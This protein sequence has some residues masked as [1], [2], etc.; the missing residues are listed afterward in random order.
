MGL[1]TQ[2]EDLDIF[3]EKPSTATKMRCHVADSPHNGQEVTHEYV[4]SLLTTRYPNTIV[5]ITA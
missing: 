3:E 2:L 1:S 5:I 4:A